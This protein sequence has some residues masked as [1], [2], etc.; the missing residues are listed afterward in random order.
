MNAAQ[1]GIRSANARLTGSVLLDGPCLPGMELPWNFTECC[2]IPGCIE[3]SLLPTDLQQN[4]TRA[5]L[6]EARESGAEFW[7]R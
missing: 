5:I 7:L 6:V 4:H 1:M 2:E 3:M